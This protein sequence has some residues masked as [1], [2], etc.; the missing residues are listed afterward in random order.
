L[1]RLELAVTHHLSQMTEATKC[2]ALTR[3]VI[4][5]VLGFCMS[6]WPDTSPAQ[7]N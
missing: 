6:R 2:I 1:T 3:S 4:A 7:L 5:S